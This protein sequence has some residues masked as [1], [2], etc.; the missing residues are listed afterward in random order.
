M[1][2]LVGM[3]GCGK[4][5][6]GLKLSE[7]YQK[8]FVDL[9]AFIVAHEGQSISQIFREEG[10]DGFR[11]L[12][13]Q[14]LAR[15]IETVASD[16]IIATGGG[17][18]CYHHNMGM[19]LH[20]GSVLYLQATMSE[21]MAHLANENDSRPLLHN[22][23]NL[24]YYLENTLQQREPFYKQAHLVLQTADISLSTFAQIFQ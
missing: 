7:A 21:L 4:T 18:P 17:T 1:L 2:F 9:D 22:N 15:V 6:W 16:S 12:E 13:H 23:P 8:P 20:A 10:E 19:M 14:Y 5:H 24:Q 11:K 3:P